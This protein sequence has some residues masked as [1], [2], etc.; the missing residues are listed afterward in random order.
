M[1]DHKVIK[2]AENLLL[3]TVSEGLC[4]RKILVGLSG[5]ADSVT[6]LR[7]LCI[8]SPKYG[9]T[10]SAC[11][12]NHMIRGAEAD[13]DQSFAEKL[14]EKLGIK[15]FTKAFDVPSIAAAE[16]K[17]LEEAAR[18][19]RYAYFDELC[20]FGE[21]DFIATAHTASDNAETILFNITRGCGL[22]GLTG[23][24]A[25]RGRIIRPLLCSERADIEDFL[26][27]I[28]QDFVTDSTNLIDDCS[29]NIIRLNVIPKLMAINP[30]FTKQMSKLSEIV[31]RENEYLER[32]AKSCFSDDIREL[33]KLD[34]VILSRI[35]G[36]MYKEL[37]G[38]LP[39]MNHIDNLCSE[40]KSSAE[41]N[42]GERK[43][44]N[45]PGGITAVFE[46][47]KIGM[48][49]NDDRDDG[50]CE[51]DF[52]PSEGINTVCNGK[53]LVVY[54]EKNE[55]N[56]ELCPVLTYNKN[57]YSL[58]METKLSGDIIRGK[59]RLRSGLPGDKIRISGMSK[60]IRKMYSAKKI[61]TKERKYLPR[62]VD[63]ESGEILALPYVGV[64]DSQH[65]YSDEANISIGLYILRG[66]E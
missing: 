42:S 1:L 16:K 5:G 2:S 17:S 25:R 18:D 7:V 62:I 11:H 48:F 29:R 24:P 56:T 49:R 45:L 52:I 4:G 35:V 40:I 27:S 32:T 8:L 44:F 58:F 15:L 51:Y 41:K 28:G 53:I 50:Y 13:R 12:I 14:C 30:S 57:I 37:C 31:I 46:C 43:S 6:L 65:E 19:V 34:D 21:A 3:E 26:L 39:G 22:G 60:D 66:K 23:I 9:F 20:G 64:C 63:S 47:G 10:L 61:P 33:A 59:I 54:S 55:I 38:N 36:M